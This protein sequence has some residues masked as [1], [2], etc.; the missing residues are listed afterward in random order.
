MLFTYYISYIK[1]IFK[2]FFT[3]YIFIRYII[4]IYIYKLTHR[5]GTVYVTS[6]STVV[7]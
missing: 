4:Y 5:R 6:L 3:D 1:I 2:I 7:Q